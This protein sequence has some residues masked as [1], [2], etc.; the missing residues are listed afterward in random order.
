MSKQGAILDSS[1]TNLQA[2]IHLI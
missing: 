1:A 2:S